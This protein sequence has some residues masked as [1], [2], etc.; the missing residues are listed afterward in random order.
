MIQL[1][2]GLLLGVGPSL[3]LYFWLRGYGN[4]DPG[5]K[6][7]CGRALAAGLLATFPVVLFSGLLY[8][9]LRVSGLSAHPLLYQAMYTFLVLAFSEEL[10]KYLAFRRF[11]RKTEY[12]YSR[13]E[14][15]V[16]M[17]IVGLGFGMSESL[18]YALGSNP[19]VMLIRGI[20]LP[21]CGYAAIVGWFYAGSVKTGRRGG[22][23][24]GLVIAW[25]LHG[26]Y[27]FSLAKEFAA[28]NQNLAVALALLLTLLDMALAAAL[29]VFV[30]KAKKSGSEPL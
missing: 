21:H 17:T 7:S 12:A 10:M 4:H 6:Q 13:Q 11:L 24:P 18:L 2:F 20:S 14:L 3:A 30:V 16:L 23:V 1:F 26:L 29:I 27:D 15:P 9:L 22:R 5:Y 8:L 25:L 28:A 19:A